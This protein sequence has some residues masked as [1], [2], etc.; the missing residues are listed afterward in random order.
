MVDSELA[1]DRRSMDVARPTEYLMCT[2]P[3]YIDSTELVKHVSVV[4]NKVVVLQCPV[5]G[6]P[7]PNITWLKDG[8]PIEPNDR[9]RF[10]MS[11]RQLELSLAEESD[12]AWYSC[13]A[14]NVAGSAKMDYN[15]TVFGSE[16]RRL[17]ILHLLDILS[18]IDFVHLLIINWS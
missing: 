12:T 17:S 6:I 13:M 15:L 4:K 18:G 9:L 3:A 10:L 16:F 11:G 8:E 7:L 2:V 14:D 1:A 5:Q